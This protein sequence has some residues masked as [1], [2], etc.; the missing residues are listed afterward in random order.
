MAD[1][2]RELRVLLRRARNHSAALAREVHPDLDPAVYAVL[3]AIGDGG[4]TRAADLVEHFAVDKAAIS[5]QVATLL[6]LGMVGRSPD[7][8]DARVQRLVITPAGAAAVEASTAA[9]RQAMRRL[10]EGWTPE[11]LSDFARSLRR[12]NDTIAR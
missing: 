12:F 7:P 11:Q 5:R 4:L 6:R 8:D 9:R 3:V 1:I 10:L 2:E